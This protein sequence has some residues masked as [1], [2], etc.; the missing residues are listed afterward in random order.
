MPCWI[1]WLSCWRLSPEALSGLISQGR[2]GDTLLQPKGSLVLIAA[3]FLFV[4]SEQLL[5][6]WIISRCIKFHSKQKRREK[7]CG[8]VARSASRCKVPPLTFALCCLSCRNLQ[9]ICPKR[10]WWEKL[11]TA[12]C[13]LQVMSCIFLLMW[14][15]VKETEARCEPAFG[16]KMFH[17]VRLA[18]VQT[19]GRLRW[20][21]FWY[22][23]DWYIFTLVYK[24]WSKAAY[25]I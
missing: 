18:L 1:C 4:S 12:A 3:P 25:L 21:S 2:T 23:L 20:L 8:G 14:P 6:A 7:W 13:V 19:S 11:H 17:Q 22:L 5:F 15:C 16:T 9:H 24:M 10:G